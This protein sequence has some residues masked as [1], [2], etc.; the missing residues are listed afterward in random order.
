MLLNNTTLF[1]QY[2]RLLTIQSTTLHQVQKETYNDENH[3]FNQYLSQIASDHDQTGS[4]N[5]RKSLN[6]ASTLKCSPSQLKI[7]V[8]KVF[9]FC[10]KILYEMVQNVLLIPWSTKTKKIIPKDWRVL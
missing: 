10:T 6:S 1:A 3:V 5:N 9:T 7:S 4:C 8:D 2:K